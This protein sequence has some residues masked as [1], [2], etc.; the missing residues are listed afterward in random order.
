MKHL[1]IV[2]I[3]LISTGLI[4]AQ[5]PKTVKIGN[6]VWMS[7][8]L[9]TVAGEKPVQTN[10]NSASG[11]KPTKTNNTENKSS[12][13]QTVTIGSQVWTTK[14]LNVTTF[15]NGDAILKVGD[16]GV[17]DNS[18]WNRADYF[19][20][21]AYCDSKNG[22]LYNWYAVNDRRGLAPVG[23]HI[24]SDAE[25]TELTNYLGGKSIAGSKMK[26]R[27]NYVTNV[28]VIESGGYYEEKWVSCKNCSYWTEKQKAN[29]PCAECRN[30]GGK[31]LK[32]GKYIPKTKREVP[33]KINLGWDG[34]NESG[35]S[36][37]PGC[38]REYL[39]GGVVCDYAMWWTR[40]PH[41]N[42]KYAITGGCGFVDSRQIGNG[43]AVR[44]IRD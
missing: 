2:L 3:F 8:N 30:K 10:N 38:H 13:Y 26:V 11:V 9:G 43:Y 25:W 31:Y 34:T 41:G 39:G 19:K 12:N 17:N 37:L 28:R 4:K 18:E 35:F 23:Y 24:P 6:Q 40:T 44:C 20:Q 33:E 22:K 32:T 27:P 14:N 15:R 1:I 7:E 5:T 16:N 29:N 36:A 42:R 21:P